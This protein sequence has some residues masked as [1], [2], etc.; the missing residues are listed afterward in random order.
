MPW[1]FRLHVEQLIPP[2]WQSSNTR[3]SRVLGLVPLGPV[4]V[5]TDL[6]D[7]SSPSCMSD[8][9]IRLRQQA[10][11][12]NLIKQQ[13]ANRFVTNRTTCSSERRC[14]RRTWL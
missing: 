4:T 2:N 14:S 3:G 7:H 10:T 6:G 13:I 9:L 1:H 5:V 12:P 8:V 11:L